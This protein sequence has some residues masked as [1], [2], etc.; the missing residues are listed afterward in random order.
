MTDTYRE[1]W[2]IKSEN[3]SLCF[4]SA[5]YSRLLGGE[6]DESALRWLAEYLRVNATLNPIPVAERPWERQGWCD[7]EGRC[8]W[9]GY[10][11]G[12]DDATVPAWFLDR[13]PSPMELRFFGYTHS[14][15]HDAL[16]VP[17]T[18]P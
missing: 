14:L 9:S 15:P 7:A 8:W 5:I 16:P 6:Q 1:S 17:L 18:P 11:A 13:P 4:A 3:G 10:D 2:D 12:H